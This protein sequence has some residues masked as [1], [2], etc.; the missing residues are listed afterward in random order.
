[1]VNYWSIVER[2]INEADIILEVVDARMIDKTRNLEIEAKVES[3]KKIL[4]KVINKCDLVEKDYLEKIKKT[5]QPCVFVSAKNFLGTTMLRQKILKYA[6]GEKVVVGV[7]GYPNTGKSSVINCLKGRASAKV[8]S[9]SGYTKGR[10]VIKADNK[11]VL[12]DTPGVLSY[13]DNYSDNSI[14]IATKNFYD[15]KDP[16]FAVLKLIKNYRNQILKHYSIENDKINDLD[17]E[18]ILE[19]IAIKLNKKK[20]GGSP[21]VVIA[22]KMILKDWQ[23]GKI[24]I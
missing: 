7:V 20:I 2:V 12:L 16:D 9:V 5:L 22:A 15:E 23:N 17:E 3:R 24:K 14:E 11:I 8:S 18:E 10:Q 6:R 13:T 19:L 21:D 4:I 1:M